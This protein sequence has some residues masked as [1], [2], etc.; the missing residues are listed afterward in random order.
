MLK[1][2]LR[3]QTNQIVTPKRHLQFRTIG[4]VLV[5]IVQNT[6]YAKLDRIFLIHAFQVDLAM[7]QV[8]Q[9]ATMTIMGETGIAKVAIVEVR[10]HLIDVGAKEMT[11]TGATLV[12]ETGGTM[13]MTTIEAVRGVIAEVEI[14]DEIERIGL[15]GI[16]LEI[17]HMR[18]LAIDLEKD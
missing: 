13:I 10:P 12:K 11:I 18:R 2:I 3:D 17:D 4:A 14:V 1:A 6:V 8:L 5:G 16:D 9:T 15:V 7:A